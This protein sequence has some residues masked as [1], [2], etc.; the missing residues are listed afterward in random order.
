M[1]SR[2]EFRINVPPEFV[3]RQDERHIVG[4]LLSYSDDGRDEAAL[5]AEIRFREDI[6]VPL[7][8]AAEVAFAEF[9]SILGGPEAVQRAVHLKPEMLPRGSIL[10]LN[11]RTWL[12]ARNEVKDPDRHLRRVRWDARSF[13]L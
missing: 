12:H 1:L 4:S 8:K 11:N 2:P 10:F 3:K 13:G 5:G 9:K 6:V 7:T